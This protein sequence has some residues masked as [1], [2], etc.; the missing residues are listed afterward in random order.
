MKKFS[1]L[2]FA[3]LAAGCASFKFIPADNA[4]KILPKTDA[5]LTQRAAELK[6][7]IAKGGHNGAFLSGETVSFFGMIPDDL[8][9]RLEMLG[10]NEAYVRYD[11]D[12]FADSDYADVLSGLIAAMKRRGITVYLAVKMSDGVWKRSDN[13]FRRNWIDPLVDEVV[14][15]FAPRLAGFQEDYPEGSFDGVMFEFD[16]EAFDKSNLDMPPGQ[17]YGWSDTSYGLG[18]DNDLL[19]QSGFEMLA[20]IKAKL[21]AREMKL[22]YGVAAPSYIP[23]KQAAGELTKGSVSDFLATAD[24]AIF[25]TRESGSNDIVR[26]ADAL[27]KNAPAHKVG[28]WLPLSRHAET[29]VPALRR[30][31]FKQFCVGL[32]NVIGS[33]AGLPAYRGA[34]FDGFDALQDIWEK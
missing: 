24:F 11:R 2:L 19:V 10:L 4:T 14:K 21:A 30:R 9:K 27:L 29:G 22:I 8:A 5:R 20:K 13:C 33:C 17:I 32:G 6:A 28:V 12:F 34:A 25:D 16:M 18:Q 3:L 31:S 23:E 15:H 7:M 26:K 1:L